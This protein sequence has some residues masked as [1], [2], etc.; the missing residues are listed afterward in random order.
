M[1]NPGDD[2]LHVVVIP[3]R[4][5]PAS[6][7]ACLGSLVAA[8]QVD[9]DFSWQRNVLRGHAVAD[10]A[11]ILTEGDIQHP[12]QVVPDLPNACGWPVQDP[13]GPPVSA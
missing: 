2:L 5:F 9:G 1:K 4:H 12:M 7:E 6:S 13:L 10:P 3:G 11:L 8:D